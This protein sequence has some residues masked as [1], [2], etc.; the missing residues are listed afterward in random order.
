MNNALVKYDTYEKFQ[1][2]RKNVIQE[3]TDQDNNTR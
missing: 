1:S 2:K 3:G